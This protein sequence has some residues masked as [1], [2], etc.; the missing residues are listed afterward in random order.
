MVVVTDDYC[1]SA[2]KDIMDI[3]DDELLILDD[4]WITI[5]DKIFELLVDKFE[6][7][8]YMNHN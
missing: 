3:L 5:H 4:Q 2:V 1:N 8:G 6:S 7:N